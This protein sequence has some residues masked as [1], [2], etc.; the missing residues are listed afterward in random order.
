ML[1]YFWK[2][3]PDSQK[4]LCF[5]QSNDDNTVTE[6]VAW[7]WLRE[8]QVSGVWCSTCITFKLWSWFRTAVQIQTLNDTPQDPCSPQSYRGS[9]GNEILTSDFKGIVWN[10]SLWTNPFRAG[11][12]PPEP[13]DCADHSPSLQEHLH[14]AK[15]SPKCQVFTAHIEPPMEHN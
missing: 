12:V 6:F 5:W 14:T 1:F 15:L 8:A 9:L 4:F 3:R 7:F 13:F 10:E 11:L 2:T